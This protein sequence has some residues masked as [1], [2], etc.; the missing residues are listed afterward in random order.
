MAENPKKFTPESL[1]PRECEIVDLVVKGYDNREISQALGMVEQ[2]VKN[3]LCRIYRKMGCKNRVQCAVM[4][5]MSDRKDR[6]IQDL[7]DRLGA[8]EKEIAKWRR[9]MG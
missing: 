8:M 7:K 2:V 1:T 4:W 6:E 5:V 9:R 3:H